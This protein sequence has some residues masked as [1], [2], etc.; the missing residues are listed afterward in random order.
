MG[1]APLDAAARARVLAYLNSLFQ[2]QPRPVRAGA[3]RW[4]TAQECCS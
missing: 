1:L 3:D 2:Y 4:R